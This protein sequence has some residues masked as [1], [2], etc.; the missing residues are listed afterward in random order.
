MARLRPPARTSHL[1][2]DCAAAG[3]CRADGWCVGYG[4]DL[5]PRATVVSSSEVAKSGRLDAGFHLDRKGVVTEA[6]GR[7]R[8][9][10]TRIFNE[11]AARAADPIS[12]HPE[13]HRFQE[14]DAHASM[15]GESQ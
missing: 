9:C 4:C 8:T 7:C 1:H 5:I 11:N 10:R 14:T 2:V 3:D 13:G 15:G 12:R 6:R